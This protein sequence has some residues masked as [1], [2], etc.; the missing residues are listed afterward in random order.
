VARASTAEFGG[1]MALPRITLVTPCLNAAATIDRT[2]AS[3][4]AQTYPNLEYI[5]RDGVSTDSTVAKILARSDLKISLASEADGGPSAALNKG[6]AGAV[7]EVFGYINADD[8]LAL[9]ALAKV[10]AFFARERD[11]DVLTGGCKRVFADGSE[12][13]TTP[14]ARYVDLLA[15]RNHFEQ[16]STFW[17]AEVHRRAGLFD[18]SYKLAFDWEWWNRLKRAGA[19]FA[20]IPDVLSLYHFSG[21]NL[22]SRAGARTIEEMYRITKTYAPHGGRIADVYKF[23]FRTFDM[24]GF[25]DRPFAELGVARRLVFGAALAALYARYGRTPVNAYNW[26]WASKQIRGIKWH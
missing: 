20:R 17:R 16:P 19:R 1:V 5:V 22:T 23:L 6:F 15:Y 24:R 26:N 25:Y 14:D 11:V 21:E 4:A 18:E 12:T 10:G 3:V 9:G 2:L 7:G 8:E 13:I